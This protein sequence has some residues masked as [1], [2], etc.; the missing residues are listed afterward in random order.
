VSSG[1]KGVV[2]GKF[3]PDTEIINLRFSATGY[4]TIQRPQN[5]GKAK[6][7]IPYYLEV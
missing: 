4:E 5:L 3:F 6:D 7:R 1:S 2:D